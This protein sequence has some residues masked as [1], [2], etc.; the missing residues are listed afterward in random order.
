[1]ELSKSCSPNDESNDSIN[2]WNKL[3]DE[4]VE[5]ILLNAIES[6]TNAIQDYH[7][8][9]K[10]CSRF[11]VVKQKGKRLFPCVYIDTHEK[12]EHPSYR[13]M[14][15]VSA[16]KLTKLFGQNSGLLLD[17]SN[18][19]KEK[20][21]KSAWLILCKEKYSWY[22]IYK[23]H[24]KNAVELFAKE[25]NPAF[26]LQ[27]EFYY[28]K[29]EDKNILMTKDAWL[30]DRIMDA[31]QKLICKALVKID[32]FHSVLNSQK[33]SNYPFIAVNPNLGGLSRVSF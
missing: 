21:W 19:I 9:M 12:F 22:V 1:M 7:S 25:E 10:I 8:I 2:L 6:S 20:K 33:R 3:P 16:R 23:V 24:W 17:I 18:I 14:I 11:Q 5:T 28:L 4:I 15:K 13:N 26:W 31:D 29:N 27:N 32:S 30:Y